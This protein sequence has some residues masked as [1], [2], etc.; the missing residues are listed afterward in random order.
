MDEQARLR[1]L[2]VMQLGS[3]ILQLCELQ[4]QVD[5]AKAKIADNDARDVERMKAIADAR[6]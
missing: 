3:Q 2:I 6:G 5:A 1:E 4:A